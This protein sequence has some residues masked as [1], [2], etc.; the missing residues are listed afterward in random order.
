[1][2]IVDLVLIGIFVTILILISLEKIEK[3]I[4]GILGGV[5]VFLIFFLTEDFLLHDLLEFIDFSVIFTILGI[6]SSAEVIRESGFFQWIGIKATQ[7][8]RGRPQ[9]LF[10]L[11]TLASGLLAGPITAIA[12]MI[13]IGNL[14][15]DVADILDIDPCPY[16]VAE[17][18]ASNAGALLTPIA[19]VP[20]I[21]IR[22]YFPQ[23]SFVFYG[24]HLVSFALLL[25]PL[26]IFI[27]S[28]RV[29][30]LEEP[31]EDRR[32]FL[33]EVNPWIVVHNRSLLM[34]AAFLFF[35]MVISLVLL[36]ILFPSVELWFLAIA[37]MFA[38][39]ALPEIDVNMVL[40]DLDW[41]I[42]FFLIGLFI[43]VEGL[44][45]Q[46][47][48]TKVAQQ[49]KTFLGGGNF[50][51]VVFVLWFSTLAS[52][53]IDDIAVTIVLLPLIEELLVPGSPL[54]EIEV[55]ILVTLI[56]S[57]NLG[58]NLTPLASPTT[59]LA[60]SLSKKAKKELT[61]KEFLKIGFFTTL[62]QVS[63]ATV[64]LGIVYYFTYYYGVRMLVIDYFLLITAFLVYGLLFFRHKFLNSWSKVGALFSWLGR[65]TEKGKP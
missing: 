6:F 28:K 40:K 43:M 8:T 53:V 24:V 56:I 62:L 12:V 20:N 7:V 38:F 59:V 63:I 54:A 31:S 64:F 58:G 51:S 10:I 27:L 32:A 21:I 48:L 34:K 23:T 45:H 30:T 46:G 50:F 19:S 44:V 13:I 1:M 42:I 16:L 37:F 60:M 4:G 65:G 49:M 15:V 55:L 36:P 9:F 11:L 22:G 14:T 5:L 61:P 18:V 33:M 2:D 35:V 25:L 52:G 3:A 26:T 17:A 41:E 47:I 29:G 39:L 57:V